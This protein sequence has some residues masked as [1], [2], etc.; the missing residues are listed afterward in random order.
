MTVFNKSKSKSMPK[1]CMIL[2]L[3][4]C[5]FLLINIALALLIYDKHNHAL[6]ESRKIRNFKSELAQNAIN[7]QSKSDI[8][9]N[10]ACHVQADL[11][12]VIIPETQLDQSY[13][14]S[15]STYSRVLFEIERATHN[16]GVFVLIVVSLDSFHPIH[17]NWCKNVQ[18]SHTCKLQVVDVLNVNNVLMT[19]NA[20]KFCGQH[21]L[22]L[23]DS[24]IVDITLLNRLRML[25]SNKV[26][27]L[28]PSISSSDQRQP[29]NVCPGTAY[30][31]PTNF[32]ANIDTSTS[33]S[34]DIWMSA[35]Q[36]NLYAGNF[37]ICSSFKFH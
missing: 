14:L 16:V 30:N 18:K 5:Y 26:S 3:T 29:Q 1:R 10:K 9:S 17:R 32:S 22:L 20:H 36:Q 11:F 6:H 25:P 15:G 2:F 35:I 13:S 23:S 34:K 21:Y 37:P 19:I 27:C 28:L 7:D 12:I 31:L 8:D 33:L 24:L 4:L